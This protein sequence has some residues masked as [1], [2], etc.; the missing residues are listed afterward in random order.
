MKSGPVWMKR[1]ILNFK[2]D[3]SVEDLTLIDGNS[4]F[5]TSNSLMVEKLQYRQ[6]TWLLQLTI[7]YQRAHNVTCI[8]Q[9][10]VKRTFLREKTLLGINQAHHQKSRPAYPTTEPKLYQSSKV[11]FASTL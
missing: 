11:Y 6:D 8:L 7:I 10:V 9:G 5:A 3:L 2:Y 4:D 1:H